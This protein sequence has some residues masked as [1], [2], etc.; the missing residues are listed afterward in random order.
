MKLLAL[1]RRNFATFDRL[2]T[3]YVNSYLDLKKFRVQR[4]RKIAKNLLE[5]WREREYFNHLG[6]WT[7]M[8]LFVQMR[9]KRFFYIFLFVLSFN[10]FANV[11]GFFAARIERSGRKYKKKFLMKR[12]PNTITYQSA[13]DTLYE[14][15][16]LSL[17]STDLLGESFIKIDRLLR[18]GVSRQL[19]IDT[20]QK[21]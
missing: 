4:E 11:L 7:R 3:H 17:Q 6:Y 2:V 9:K 12:Y 18:D 5:E 8:K 15:K 1:S 19:I 14:P 10:Y 21:V 16:K 20:F 13:L